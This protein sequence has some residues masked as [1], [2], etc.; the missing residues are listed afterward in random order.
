MLNRI[1]WRSK[2]FKVYVLIVYY[3]TYRKKYIS[4][5]FEYFRIS[6]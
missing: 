1:W 4:R 5:G 6:N 2:H 3:W